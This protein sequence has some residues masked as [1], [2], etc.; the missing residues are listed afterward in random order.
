[1]TALPFLLQM[2]GQPGSGK[3]SLARVIGHRTAAVVLDKDVLKT[4]I[5]DS[6]IDEP[7][8]CGVAY[9]VFFALADHLVG[10]GLAVVLDSPSF[11]DQIPEKGAAIAAA[12]L[13]AYY[14]IE[15]VCPDEIEHARRL[16][17]RSGLR[18]NPGEEAL[19][20]QAQTVTP[21]GGHLRVDTTKPIEQTLAV[22]LEYLGQS[23]MDG[24]L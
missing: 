11:Y 21:S 8:A 9:E 17:E 1:M 18:S 6:G 20:D 13:V 23:P 12:R 2:A 19:A 5:L 4:A 3:S 10:Q 24:L 7:R 15:C 22:A 14:F 16:R